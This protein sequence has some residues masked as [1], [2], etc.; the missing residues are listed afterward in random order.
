MKQVKDRKQLYLEKIEKYHA[1]LQTKINEVFPEEETFY[2]MIHLKKE[3]FWK[4]FHNLSLRMKKIP[5]IVKALNL[6]RQ[7]TNQ[8][9][10]GEDD[11]LITGFEALKKQIEML[12]PE[13]QKILLEKIKKEF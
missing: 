13:E 10:F 9:F 4:Q 3:T 6:S 8:I 12:T 11:E 1:M 5:K 2:K 7:E